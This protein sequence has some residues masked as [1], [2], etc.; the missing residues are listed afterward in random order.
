MAERA[1]VTAS[2]NLHAVS[3]DA[4]AQCL[5]LLESHGFV[6]QGAAWI[7]SS[8]AREWRYYI[9]SGLVD[10]DG[11]LATYD[12]IMRL[13]DALRWTGM[14][15]DDV[16]LGSPDEPM[17]KA[18]AAALHVDNAQVKLDNVQVDRFVIEH[19]LV[20]RMAKAPIRTRL[21]EARKKFDRHLS[22]ME[23]RARIGVEVD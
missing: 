13:F 4:G 20:Y 18:L 8:V 23:A 10:V 12:R 16:H 9:V 22:E 1:S 15:I 6:V 21:Q 2:D 11:L 5:A 3:A 7:F 14:S 17:F 19:A